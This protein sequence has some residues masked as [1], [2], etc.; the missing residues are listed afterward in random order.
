MSSRRLNG[1]FHHIILLGNKLDHTCGGKLNQPVN[2]TFQG[3]VMCDGNV[4]HQRE[5]E[6]PVRSR[7]RENPLSFG[8]I[9]T[10]IGSGG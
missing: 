1:F 3:H 10:L 8:L 7:S 2:Y 6:H 9:P 5:R 4:M